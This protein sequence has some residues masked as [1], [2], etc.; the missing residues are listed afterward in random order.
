MALYIILAMVGSCRP[1]GF[2]IAFDL[3][4]SD[5]TR[6]LPRP[7]SL[8]MYDPKDGDYVVHNFTR[9]RYQLQ[10]R[11]LKALQELYED[12]V[13]AAVVKY[14]QYISDQYD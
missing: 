9:I 10:Y 2:S 13:Y 6:P 8:R 7:F 11:L 14:M 3:Y 1:S 5:I 12:G 4:S